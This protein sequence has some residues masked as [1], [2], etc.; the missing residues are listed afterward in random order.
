M[1]QYERIFWSMS[2]KVVLIDRDGTLNTST[3][4]SFV[5][6]VADFVL[7]PGAAEAIRLLTEN[8]W[9]VIVV[10]NQGGVG[11]G[12]MTEAVLCQ[13]HAKMCR[14]IEAGGGRIHAIYAC[15]HAVDAG[16]ACRKPKTGFIGEMCQQHGFQP[17][18]IRYMIG[19]SIDDVEFAKRAGT[20][21]LL[22]RTGRGHKTEQHYASLNA[23]LTVFDNLLEA[24]KDILT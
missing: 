21:S 12:F 1:C 11:A 14:E 2:K 23:P 5:N 13:I 22:V 15:T 8:D 19:D 10:T 16:C 18:D 24:V 6:A 4:G 9:T 20:T 17:I 7:L 3:R